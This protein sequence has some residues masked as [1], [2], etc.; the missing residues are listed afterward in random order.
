MVTIKGTPSSKKA[1]TCSYIM[2]AAP[3][4]NDIYRDIVLLG[5]HKKELFMIY[6]SG[7]VT[8]CM[9]RGRNETETVHDNLFTKLR[10]IFWSLKTAQI[11]LAC[12]F[13][14]LI[15]LPNFPQHSTSGFFK[16]ILF[17]GCTAF[18]GLLHKE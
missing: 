3:N 7:N 8:K 5:L 14:W 15:T 18:K 1:T 2:N 9:M 16:S 12:H 6:L 11:G 10:W 13:Y 4:I 17:P